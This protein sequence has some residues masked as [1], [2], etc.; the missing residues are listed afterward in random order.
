MISLQNVCKSYRL[1]KGRHI[2]LDDVSYDFVP[3]TNVG[4]L[5]RNGAGKSTMMR[6]ISGNEQPDKGKVVRRSTISWPIGFSGGFN[7]KLSGRDNLRFVCRLY[8]KNYQEVVSFVEDFAELG[9]HMDMPIYTYSSGMRSKLNFGMSMA[10]SFDYYLVDEATAVGD[11]GFRRKSEAL[12]EE[13]RRSSTLLVVS[14]SMGT[15]KALCDKTLVLYEGKLLDLGSMDEA[16][17]FYTEV[18]CRQKK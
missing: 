5:G 11:A 1:K 7:S 13:R 4:I 10:F 18:C 9:K 2:V 6:I 12:F 15:I 17:K 8:A 16:Q 14:H 3:G